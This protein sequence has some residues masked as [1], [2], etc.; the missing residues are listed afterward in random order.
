[1]SG[2]LRDFIVVMADKNNSTRG[3]TSGQYL[4]SYN[5]RSEG[6]TST[7]KT[8]ISVAVFDAEDDAKQ[9][10]KSSF[11]SCSFPQKNKVG[12]HVHIVK[13]ITFLQSEQGYPSM[14]RHKLILR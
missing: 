2:Q 13:A 6:D 1:M 5:A 3:T 14:G 12:H 10:A 8:M 9:F 7:D 4:V 11:T